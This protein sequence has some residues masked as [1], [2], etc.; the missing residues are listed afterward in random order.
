MRRLGGS[1]VLFWTAPG[2]RAEDEAD[3][4]SNP[5]RSV[6]MQA[7]GAIRCFGALDGL[8]FQ[9]FAPGFDPLRGADE[10]HFGFLTEIRGAHFDQFLD[11]LRE[12]C[13]VLD[14]FLDRDLFAGKILKKYFHSDL[15]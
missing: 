10:L 9:A 12:N 6:R 13:E 11:V 14:K 4:Y 2:K 5:N 7:N 15:S 3:T 1:L 8:R